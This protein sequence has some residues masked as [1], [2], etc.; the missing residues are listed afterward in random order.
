MSLKRK[1]REGQLVTPLPLLTRSGAA[2]AAAGE[3]DSYHFGVRYPIPEYSTML[4]FS[5]E[6]TKIVRLQR[7][8]LL[9]SWSR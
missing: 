3:N 5:F 4:P 2:A 6:L 9:L 1:G 7:Y 8:L